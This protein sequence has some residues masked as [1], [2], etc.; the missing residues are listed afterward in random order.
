VEQDRGTRVLD[1]QVDGRHRAPSFEAEN[2]SHK[3]DVVDKINAELITIAWI[4]L[5]RGAFNKYKR[6][7]LR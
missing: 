5:R 6:W 1:L 3:V 7:R 2:L 4:F